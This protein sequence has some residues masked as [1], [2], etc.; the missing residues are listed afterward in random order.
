MQFKCNLSAVQKL[1]PQSTLRDFCVP[2][3][4][5]TPHTPFILAVCAGGLRKKGSLCCCHACCGTV[6]LI[7]LVVCGMAA[8]HLPYDVRRE[9]GSVRRRGNRQHPR[10]QR[11][12]EARQWQ[13]QRRICAVPGGQRWG[14]T[15]CM[16]PVSSPVFSRLFM[17]M[18]LHTLPAADFSYEYVQRE[19]LRVPLI[20][21]EKD[22]LGI[23]LANSPPGPH[24]FWLVAEG[25]AL[26]EMCLCK[27]KLRELLSF[28]C[29][30]C[31]IRSS[32]SVRLKAWWVSTLSQTVLCTYCNTC[33]YLCNL[34]APQTDSASSECL[35]Y[36]LVS[37]MAMLL[38]AVLLL[39]YWEISEVF[40]LKN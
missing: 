8:L 39:K 37:S 2:R 19:A 36:P 26:A 27:D 29:S 1:R 35:S 18:P 33:I 31:L 12:G 30:E 6:T 34:A 38:S 28:M 5:P 40:Y 7:I 23:R 25:N 4:A 21:K 22:G 20:F 17:H 16:H 13:L 10:V 14:H 15:V 32:L 24:R 11:G 3:Y 9:R